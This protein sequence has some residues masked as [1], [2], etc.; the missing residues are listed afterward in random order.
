[1]Y[2]I[3]SKSVRKASIHL[4][5]I[6][7]IKGEDLKECVMRFNCEAVLILYLEDRIAYITFLNGLFPGQFKFFLAQSKV[8]TVAD[9]LR[10][11]QYFTQ[12][13]EIC[14]GDDSV[15]QETRKRIGEDKGAPP[16]KRPKRDE[17]RS[18]CFHTVP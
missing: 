10:R 18:G 4:T 2:F 13:I 1:M 7:Q 16:D 17:E 12:A 3:T 6:G 5:Q 15:H 11:A 8:S 9:A 14:T